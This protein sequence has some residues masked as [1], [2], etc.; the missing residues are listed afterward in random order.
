MMSSEQMNKIY[1]SNNYGDFKILKFISKAKHS[2]NDVYEIEFIDTK[3]RRPATAS[4]IRKGEVRDYSIE[5]R[6]RFQGLNTESKESLRDGTRN[7]YDNWINILRRCNSD[8][9]YKDVRIS[10]EWL[11]YSNFKKFV[12]D[13]ENGYRPEYKL[14]KDLFSD[15]DDRV[16]SKDTCVFIP[17]LINS[18][19][20]DRFRNRYSPLP[21][22]VQIYTKDR[23][24]LKMVIS[25]KYRFVVA[26]YFNKD[27]ILLAFCY[28]KLAK[29]CLLKLKVKD[30]YKNNELCEKAYNKLMDFELWD[31]RSNG[32][33][34]DSIKSTLI[35]IPKSDIKKLYKDI[36][37]KYIEIESK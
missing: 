6:T 28:Y 31:S 27:Q 25:Y 23:N 13:P 24:R 10:N 29:E 15:P 33:D 21:A 9:A 19:L 3:H 12:L 32:F 30:L 35:K 8:R 4:N 14:D 22:G 11:N 17:P 26:R 34:I 7:I 36:Y 2:A 5:K 18:M 20:V 16:Y 37:K 1:K